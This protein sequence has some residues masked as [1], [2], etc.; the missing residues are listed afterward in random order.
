M[1]ISG[2]GTGVGGISDRVT[3][4]LHV[5]I[6]GLD[7]R[8]K[9]IASNVANLE[10]SGYLAEEVNFEDSLRS[11]LQSGDPT[12]AAVS[13]SRSMAATRLNGNNVNIDFELLAGSE[14]V[15]RQKL[16][17]QA[18]NS[19]YQLLRTAIGSGQ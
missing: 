7:A 13:H 2:V 17:V 6:N 12:S 3:Q 19:K 10:T 5:A 15:L 9:A 8:E 14:N 11:A 4:A 1:S 18:L 16:V